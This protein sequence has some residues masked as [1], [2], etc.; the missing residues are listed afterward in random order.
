MIILDTNVV[1]AMMSPVFNPV[2]HAFTARYP[3]AELYLPSLV[4]AEIRFGTL[5]LPAGKRQTEIQ[6]DFETFLQ[7]GFS[8]RILNFNA[9]CALGYATA[10][11]KRQASGRPVSILDALTGGMALA[12]GA[13]LATRNT[14]D[15]DGYG[16][17]LIDPWAG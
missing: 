4:M 14:A 6:S 11:A 13:T 3:S 15:F 16:L 12:Y 17:T 9:D 7:R 2:I 1:S 5:R 10:R 8:G